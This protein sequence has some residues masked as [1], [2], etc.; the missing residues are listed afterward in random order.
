M[1]HS[2]PLEQQFVHP[3]GSFQQHQD[4]DLDW[5]LDIALEGGTGSV[6]VWD[7]DGSSSWNPCSSR[8]QKVICFCFLNLDN[9]S[10]LI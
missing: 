5:T 6:T 2:L 4:H 10:L 3:A 8:K 1:A 7:W 9:F